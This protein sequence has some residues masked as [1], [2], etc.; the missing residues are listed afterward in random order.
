M[1]HMQQQSQY[2]PFNH[3]WTLQNFNI[4]YGD[5]FRR[6]VIKRKLCLTHIDN[7]VWF[8]TDIECCTQISHKLKKKSSTALLFSFCALALDKPSGSFS[9]ISLF[10]RKPGNYSLPTHILSLSQRYFVT[11]RTIK[12]EFL[13]TSLV[14]NASV[15]QLRVKSLKLADKSWFF[16]HNLNCRMTNKFSFYF[17]S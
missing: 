3:W 1:R 10:F 2:H 7:N 8:V 15:K 6:N 4:F 14:R 9:A 17:V 12:Q 11:F 16:P 5:S 13:S